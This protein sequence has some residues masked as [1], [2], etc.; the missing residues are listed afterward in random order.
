MMSLQTMEQAVAYAGRNQFA[1]IDITGGGAGTDPAYRASG[2][3]PRTI[4]L[5]LDATDKPDGPVTA[6]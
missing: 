1:T 2:C 5:T 6:E 3:Q 4:N